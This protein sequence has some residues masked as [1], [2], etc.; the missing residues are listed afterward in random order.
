MK[1]VILSLS[2]L[3]ASLAVFSQSEKYI[4]AMQKNITELDGAMQKGNFPELAN[5]FERIGDAEKTQWL[6]YYYAA[7]ATVSSSYLEKDKSKNDGIADKAEQL[8]I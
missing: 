5:N 1:K 7:Y 3:V 8:I 4:A 6:P 2:F